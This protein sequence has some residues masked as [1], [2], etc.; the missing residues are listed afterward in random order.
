MADDGYGLSYL[1]TGHTLI[2]HITSKKSSSLTVNRE[3]SLFSSLNKKLTLRNARAGTFKVRAAA[4]VALR[5]F[6]I[7][8][9]ASQLPIDTLNWKIRL[10]RYYSGLSMD[11]SPIRQTFK[12]ENNFS[13][14]G[15]SFLTLVKRLVVKY[16][17][18]SRI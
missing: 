9:L 14:T 11:H 16:C 3:D 12:F 4:H 15:K 2:V 5:M 17:K 7:Q 13:A 8:V 18:M 6:I 1:I 10:F